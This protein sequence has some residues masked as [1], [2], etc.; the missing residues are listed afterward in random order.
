[1]EHTEGLERIWSRDSNSR[2]RYTHLRGRGEEYKGWKWLDQI[3]QAPVKLGIRAEQA[4][5]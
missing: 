5:G 2:R 3:I 1:L 4:G